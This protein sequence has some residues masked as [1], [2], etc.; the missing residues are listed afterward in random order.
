[1]GSLRVHQI[2]VAVLTAHA[3]A[4]GSALDRLCAACVDEL[5]VSG[6][7]LALMTSAG[8]GGTLAASGGPAEAMENLQNG[9]GEGPCLD[10]FRDGRPVLQS[11]LASTGTA[12]WPGFVSG[13]LE[14]GVT[15]AFAFPLQVGAIRLGVLDLYRDATGPL[16]GAE[17]TLALDFAAAATTL[18]LD[19]QNKTAPGELHPHLADAAAGHREIHQATGMITVQATVGMTEALL[20]LRARAYADERPLLDLAKDVVARRLTFRPEDDPS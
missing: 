11:D 18:V 8:H 4:V 14:A 6:A 20:L 16:T 7:G 5:P 2:L 1:M 15:A 3:D 17:L 9:L 13:A 10:A 12:L 19:L